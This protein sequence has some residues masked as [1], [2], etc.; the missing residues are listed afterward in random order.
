MFASF[1]TFFDSLVLSVISQPLL[2]WEENS[3][4][5]NSGHA[6][7]LNKRAK[8]AVS[9]V[10]GSQVEAWQKLTRR[11]CEKRGLRVSVAPPFRSVRDDLAWV[12]L[13]ARAYFHPLMLCSSIE[14]F[15][16]HFHSCSLFLA[17]SLALRLELVMFALQPASHAR[18]TNASL[19]HTTVE[20][21]E[22]TTK[23]EKFR[24]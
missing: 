1:F 21:F 23:D 7:E 16:P 3:Q 5:E 4:R 10:F 15:S 2:L 24:N 9:S 11:S 13:A 22:A 19:K 20:H 14:C 12:P 18:K 6:S 8:S 17:R